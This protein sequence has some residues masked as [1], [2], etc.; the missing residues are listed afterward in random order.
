MK[1]LYIKILFFVFILTAF[2]LAQTDI[3]SRIERIENGLL[4]P[5]HIKNGPRWTIQE[6]LKHYGIQG[7]SIAIIHNFKVE[8]ARGYGITDIET[9]EPITEKILFQAASISKPVAAMGALKKVQEGKITLFENINN[10]LT[11]W[12]LPENQ[13]TRDK[14]VTLAHL[15]SHT[16]GVT[17]HG[18]RGY[19]IDED[20]PSL[21]QVLNG[22]KPAN[23]APIRV[24]LKPGTLNRYSGGG[25]TIMQQTLIDIEKKSFPK[26]MGETVLEPL[27]MLN[28]TYEQPLLPDRLKFA[29][30]GHRS[31]E[32]SVHGKRHTYPEMAAAGLWT[33][34]TDLAKFAAEIQLSLKGKSNKILSK[35][36]THQMLT[37]FISKNYG[38]GLSIQNKGNSIYFGHG[39]S[40]EGFKCQLIAHKEKGYGAAIMT[41]A[42]EGFRIVPEIL[43]SIA[44]EY[45]W[46]DYLLEE[47]EIVKIDPARL[48]LFT[49]RFL[50]NFDDIA[51]V[52]MEKGQIFIERTYEE[53]KAEIFPIAENEFI[54]IYSGSRFTFNIGKDKKPDELIIIM[55]NGRRQS[56]SRI[57]DNYKPPYEYLLAGEVAEAIDIYRKIKKEE[58]RNRMVRESRF[59]QLGYT[60][61]GKK[62]FEKAIAL[63]KLNVEIYPRSANTYDSLAEAYATC[64]KKKL[65]IDYYSKV[66]EIIPND[67]N[68]NK[69]TLENLRK[70]ANE[71]IVQL[72]E[73]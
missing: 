60:L 3:E 69:A 7:V 21:I 57:L 32:T 72:K 26:I 55:N 2:G 25:F 67:P 17:V 73:N 37:P 34:P 23:S 58:P 14:K 27:G 64:G 10:K 11:S 62:E 15:L 66:L 5:V 38:L 18:F 12:K 54:N 50:I 6:R 61:L 1:R 4:P 33:T 40:N 44:K 45:Q 20:T 13:L 22:K 70:G 71:K 24:D 43:R 53:G 35:E 31:A 68:P 47:L 42:D 9:Q 59:N 8:W 16:G 65:A 36:L 63:F 49:G 46:A 48:D 41:N 28:S 56:A 39:G 19:A 51:A 30:A 29:A 52:L